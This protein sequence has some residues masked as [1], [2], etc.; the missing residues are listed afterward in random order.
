MQFTLSVCPRPAKGGTDFSIP[1]GTSLTS[2][3]SQHSGI[4]PMMAISLV[5]W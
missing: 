3:A 1:S 5:M 2:M 4:R